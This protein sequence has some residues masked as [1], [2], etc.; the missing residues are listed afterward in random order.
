MYDVEERITRS[1]DLRA[2]L[3]SAHIELTQMKSL[4][5]NLRYGSD[6]N[7]ASLLVRLRMGEDIAQVAD[8]ESLRSIE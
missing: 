4:I 2:R 3:R 1:Q 6:S 7:A 8:V 5:H